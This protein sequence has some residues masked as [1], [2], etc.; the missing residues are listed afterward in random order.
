MRC[1]LLNLHFSEGSG[2]RHLQLWTILFNAEERTA[3]GHGPSESTRQQVSKDRVL[4]FPCRGP[5]SASTASYR[6]LLGARQFDSASDAGQAL[7]WLLLSRVQ[8][9]PGSQL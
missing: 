8:L 6:G 2:S 1:A 7:A 9:S 5:G 4:L 3:P